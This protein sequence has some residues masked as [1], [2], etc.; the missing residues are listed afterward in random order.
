MLDSRKGGTLLQ[1]EH[2]H[3]VPLAFPG[4]AFSVH[5]PTRLGPAPHRPPRGWTVC[6]GYRG[7]CLHEVKAS[8]LLELCVAIE[9][10]LESPLSSV[11]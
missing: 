6:L 3:Y 8:L 10:S 2:F 4:M 7:L 9:D 5:F 1:K 11:L